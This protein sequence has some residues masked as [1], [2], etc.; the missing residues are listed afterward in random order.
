MGWPLPVENGLER[1][2]FDRSDTVYVVAHGPSGDVCGCGRLLP[3][4][5]SYL[6]KEVFPE[7]VGEMPLPCDPRIWELSRFAISPPAGMALSAP[8]AGQTPVA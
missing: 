1:D 7:L 3:T 2:D 4:H 5:T 6:L 8:E